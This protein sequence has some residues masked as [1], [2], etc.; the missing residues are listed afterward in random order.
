MKEI[1]TKVREEN[2]SINRIMPLIELEARRGKREVTFDFKS[3]DE[4]GICKQLRNLGYSIRIQNF[5]NGDKMTDKMTV[6][7]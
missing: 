5:M 1:T 6:S 4:W 7:W 2:S 3:S